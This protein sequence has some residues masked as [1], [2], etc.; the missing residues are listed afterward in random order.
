MTAKE[1]TQFW[2]IC[3]L[4]TPPYR[5]PDDSLAPNQI[6]QGVDSYADY[7]RAFNNDRLSD[8]AL[9]AEVARVPP[10]SIS[11]FERGKRKPS[12]DT[13]LRLARNLDVSIDYL[14]GRTPNPY[15]HTS[16]DDEP[17]P[18]LLTPEEIE[19]VEDYL[20]YLKERSS[21][22]VGPDTTTR[23]SQDPGDSVSSEKE[24]D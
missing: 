14:V 2:R 10:S 4:E 5:H 7:V 23:V 15:A 11:H 21:Y 17:P 12:F 1:L 22:P 18:V 16:V 19:K 24:P 9:L 20:A 8:T 3:E 13:L 6:Q